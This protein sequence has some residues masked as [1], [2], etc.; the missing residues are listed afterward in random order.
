MG[1]LNRQVLHSNA[2]PHQTYFLIE[3]IISTPVNAAAT[4]ESV[5]DPPTE[6]A[7]DATTNAFSPKLEKNTAH[8][9][10]MRRSKA[11]QQR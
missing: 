2:T 1:E 3:F 11:F 10:I 4:R 5:T 8:H 7:T 6:T 9:S